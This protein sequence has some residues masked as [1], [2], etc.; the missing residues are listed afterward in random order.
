MP[1][2]K[3]ISRIG[4]Q[5]ERMRHK[6]FISSHVKADRK[7]RAGLA[8]RKLLTEYEFET[9]LDVG[10]GAGMHSEVFL[11]AGKRVTAVDLGNSHYFR[12][13]EGRIETQIG[14]FLTMKFPTQY[15]CVW[16]SHVLEHQLNVQDFLVKLSSCLRE[17]GVL[18]IT[19]PPLKNLIV[20]GH[21]SLWNGGLLLYRLVLAGM[22]CRDARLLTYNNN[23]SA[24]VPKHTINVL[25]M[26]EYD[27]GDIRKI[28]PYLPQSLKFVAHDPVD[29]PFDGEILSLNW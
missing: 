11:E 15:D 8:I 26:I 19:V 18:A 29:T 9:V 23:I 21:V 3:L 28:K 12:Q 7:L 14:D 17:G 6:R 5:F 4:R 27:R 20:G 16:C 24:L 10:C 13:N 25:D 2:V 22:D 1:K